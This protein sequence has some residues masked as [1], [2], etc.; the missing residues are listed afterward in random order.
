MRTLPVMLPN[1]SGGIDPGFTNTGD[2]ATHS[3]LGYGRS[4]L[5]RF[6]KLICLDHP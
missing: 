5:R 6:E 4:D 2:C 1:G 3:A